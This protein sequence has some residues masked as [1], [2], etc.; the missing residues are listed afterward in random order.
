MAVP[1]IIMGAVA[2]AKAGYDIYQSE[3]QKRKADKINPIRPKYNIPSAVYDNAAMY[4]NLANSNRVPGQSIAENQINQNADQTLGAAQNSLSNSSDIAA[5]L[6]GVNRNKNN[7]M[8]SLFGQGAQMRL[9]N[10]DKNANANMTLAGYQDKQFGYSQDEPYR[11]DV[12]RKNALM[13]ASL[14][15]QNKAVDDLAQGASTIA[16]GAMASG[17]V[18]KGVPQTSPMTQIVAKGAITPQYG[19]MPKQL[20]KRN[21]LRTSTPSSVYDFQDYRDIE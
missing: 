7:S 8:N 2:A 17:A 16:Q 6:S 19:T 3:E 21:Y 1:L 4:K 12:A 18:S 13:D 5:V 20:L 11:E 14:A 15:N 9:A 10:M